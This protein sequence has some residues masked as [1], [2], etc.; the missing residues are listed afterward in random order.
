MCENF[1]IDIINKYLSQHNYYKKEY[2]KLDVFIRYHKLRCSEC[3]TLLSY[4][5]FDKDM[6]GK[7]FCIYFEKRLKKFIYSFPIILL[8]LIIFLFYFIF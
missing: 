1:K 8:T 7:C 3:D 4:K 5:F 6:C 2:E